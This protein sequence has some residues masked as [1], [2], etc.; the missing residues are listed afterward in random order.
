MTIL[1]CKTILNQK[2]QMKKKQ[3]ENEDTGTVLNIDYFTKQV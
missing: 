3:W 2:P 1:K